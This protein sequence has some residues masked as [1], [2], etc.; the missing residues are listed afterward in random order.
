MGLQEGAEGGLDGEGHV[1][2]LV[3]ITSLL[4][5]GNEDWGQQLPHFE[6]TDLQ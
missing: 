4:L 6:T 3:H 2:T 5:L 1:F